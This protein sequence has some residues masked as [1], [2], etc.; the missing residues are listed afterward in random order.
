M[1]KWF[2][3]FQGPTGTIDV[4]HVKRL[5]DEVKDHLIYLYFYFQGEPSRVHPQFTE[6]VGFAASRV[7]IYRYLIERTLPYGP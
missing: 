7:I 5:V 1:P 2:A 3:T 4:D 6:M